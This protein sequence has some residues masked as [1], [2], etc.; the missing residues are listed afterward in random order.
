MFYDDMLCIALLHYYS[1]NTSIKQSMP[2]SRISPIPLKLNFSKAAN[3]GPCTLLPGTL[4]VFPLLVIL[5][6]RRSKKNC[7]FYVVLKIEL[8]QLIHKHLFHVTK[9][10]AILLILNY[11]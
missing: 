7:P 4:H 2:D 11:H 3:F 8:I 6:L 10:T 9:Q 1:V 5:Y